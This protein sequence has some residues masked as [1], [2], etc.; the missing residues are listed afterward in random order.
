[1]AAL[2]VTPIEPAPEPAPLSEGARLIDTFV[3]PSKTFTDLLRNSSWWA[4][5]LIITLFSFAFLWVVGQQIGFEQV[6]HNQIQLSPSRAD[7]FDK[8]PADQ[9]AHQL[10]IAA[11]FT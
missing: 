3:A 8:L 9:Q 5:F 2:P 1:M 7:Q 10:E 6:A 4:P 11:K